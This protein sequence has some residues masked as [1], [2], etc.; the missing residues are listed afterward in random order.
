MA[1][2]SPWMENYGGGVLTTIMINNGKGVC[3]HH[4]PH[5]HDVWK[6][7]QNS[8]GRYVPPHYRAKAQFGVLTHVLAIEVDLACID[9]F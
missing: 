9:I 8:G 4:P 6:A 1:R 2:P 5:E 3:A 7:Q